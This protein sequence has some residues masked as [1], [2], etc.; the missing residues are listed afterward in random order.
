MLMHGQS[1]AN[2][3]ELLQLCEKKDNDVF[4][5]TLQRQKQSMEALKMG[6]KV[7]EDHLYV[8]TKLRSR[9]PE[10]YDYILA[11]P[12]TDDKTRRD[13]QGQ[14]LRLYTSMATRMPKQGPHADQD[15]RAQLREK[16]QELAHGL[17]ILRISDDLAW[18]MH[19]GCVD[20]PLARL[21]FD[22]LHT[23]IR[24]FPSSGR[25]ASFRAFLALVHDPMYMADFEGSTDAQET[26]DLLQLALDGFEVCPESLLCAR[27]TALFYLLD[28]DYSSALDV[29]LVAK[30]LLQRTSVSF[31]LPLTHVSMELAAHLATVYAHLHAPKHHKASLELA[32]QVLSYDMH[33]IDALLA[34]AYVR[35]AAHAWA[36]ARED[37]HHVMM[38]A[39]GPINVQGR[40]LG[41]LHLSADYRLEAEAEHAHV[42][43]ELG[44]IDAAQ[45][46]LDTLLQTHDDAGN[47]FGDEFRA[48]L[49][50]ELGRCL[51]ARGGS[52]RT[53][54]DHAYHCFVTSIQRCATYAPVFTSL[55]LYYLDALS[56]PDTVRAFK[57][58]QRAFEL[59]ARQFVAAERM[60]NQY[61][62][63]RSWEL[64]DAIA[65]RVIEAEGGID[66]LTGATPAV[67]VT[68]N[69]WAWKAMG[70][71]H[72]MNARTEPAISALQV[73]IRAAPDDA[74]AWARLGEAYVASGRPVPGLKAYARARS[75]L[76]DVDLKDAWHIEYNIAEAQRHLGRLELSIELLE[77]ILRAVPTQQGVRV[78][79]AQTRLV[80]ARHLLSSGYTYRAVEMLQ[81][82]IVNAAQGIE[83]DAKLRTAWKVV[84]DACYL[85]SQI[86]L[87]EANEIGDELQQLTLLLSRQNVD[88]RLPAISVV[89]ASKMLH[90][91]HNH[92][93]THEFLELAILVYK[94]LAIVHAMDERARVFAWA[95]LATALCRYSWVVTTSTTMARHSNPNIEAATSQA[96]AARSQGMEC[97]NL[98]LNIQSH[99]RLWILL[100]NLNFTHN[101]SMAQHAYIVAIEANRKSPVPWSNLGFLYLSVREDALAEEAFARAKTL[102][103]DWPGSWLGSALI[104]RLHLKDASASTRLFQQ[105]CVLSNGSLLDADYGLAEAAWKSTKQSMSIQPIRAMAPFLALKRYLA[106]IPNDDA[107][108]HLNALLA[109]QLGSSLLAARQIER[110]SVLIE[111]EFEATESVANAVRYGMAS[112]N[113]GRIR[114]NK[115]DTQGAIDAFE[116]ALSLLEDAGDEHPIPAT[117]AWSAIGLGWAQCLVGDTASGMAGLQQVLATLPSLSFA[118]EDMPQRIHA[119]AAVLLARFQWRLQVPVAEI[120]AGLDAAL[121]V[122]PQDPL[123]I[124]TRAA[125]ASVVGDVAQYNMVLAKLVAPLPPAAQTS[126]RNAHKTAMLSMLHLA[127]SFDTPTLLQHLASSY[128]RADNTTDTLV[129]VAHTHLRVAAGCAVQGK[130]LPALPLPEG[131]DGNLLPLA[132]QVLSNVEQRASTEGLTHWSTMQWV[133]GLAELMCAEHATQTTVD[134]APSS[135]AAQRH[136]AKAVHLAPWSQEAWNALRVASAVPSDKKPTA[137]S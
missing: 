77:R 110:A 96:D 97:V 118:E 94:Y 16:A 124:T 27:I 79:L 38:Q 49:W 105:A 99:V 68:T 34:R 13:I 65:R 89:S 61:A 122:A 106:R 29:L 21:P 32:E 115:A 52:F 73:A 20:E 90:H 116:A 67:H 93:Y 30:D 23:Y 18:H 41:A 117:R 125:L 133:V 4:H 55:G 57:C 111:S 48:R 64:V 120:A 35:T 69:P 58:L 50:H 3:L 123:L 84:G 46:A 85:L 40:F 86:D 33:Q 72:A 25:A 112:L 9:L 134:P 42:L 129:F 17:V 43:M 130:P 88:Q 44:D 121:D 132:R 62:D 98:A 76:G 66:V 12:Y 80:Q 135:V 78:V 108:L 100:G 8:Q 113:L 119:S 15:L 5:S 104:H 10:L 95:D 14:Q 87:P 131:Q 60:L 54:S 24:L 91:T 6:A 127:A 70:M 22:E 136:S 82:A 128:T 2:A 102:A 126:L 26:Q 45:Q 56:P 75:L 81:L 103:P 59:D 11:H 83:A 39:P 31:Q 63:E 1:L 92:M 36:D 19:L 28:K 51:W 47:V 109:E 71:V 7:F 137:V 53:D 37:F 74:D 101:V 107:A 114:L